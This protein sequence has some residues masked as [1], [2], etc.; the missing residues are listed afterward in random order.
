MKK[1]SVLFVYLL[2][3]VVSCSTRDSGFFLED[4]EL[5]DK[6]G[7]FL[8]KINN[9]YPVFFDSELPNKAVCESSFLGLKLYSADRE[10]FINYNPGFAPVLKYT[11]RKVWIDFVDFPNQAK[12]IAHSGHIGVELG[13]YCLSGIFVLDSCN[14]KKYPVWV[15][16]ENFKKGH[17]E[18]WEKPPQ[19]PKW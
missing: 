13:V 8:K 19:L 16:K 10:F 18:F 17:L 9:D 7:N 5:Y 4:K 14:Y 15:W 11:Q 6:S 1:L 3:F 2:F 12:K